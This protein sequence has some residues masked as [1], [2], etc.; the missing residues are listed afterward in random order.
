M[1]L[2]LV[3]AVTRVSSI[4]SCAALLIDKISS[5]RTLCQEL[6][7]KQLSWSIVTF[8]LNKACD[9]GKQIHGAQTSPLQAL[10]TASCDTQVSHSASLCQH[11]I[12]GYI[13]LGISSGHRS[14]SHSTRGL[15]PFAQ[16]HQNQEV[17]RL[18]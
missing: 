3:V 5:M 2:T 8:K 12:K 16:D 4:E 6:D 15:L 17:D 1:F 18:V 10:L 9:E 11:M 13:P 7:R 14:V